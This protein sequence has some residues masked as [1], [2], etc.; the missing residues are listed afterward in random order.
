MRRSVPNGTA[1]RSLSAGSE[2]RCARRYPVDITIHFC[3][4]T[5]KELRWEWQAAVQRGQ[6]R[7]DP[8]P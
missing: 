4:P 8:P 5:V 7:L 3:G 2:N 6:S 1:Y